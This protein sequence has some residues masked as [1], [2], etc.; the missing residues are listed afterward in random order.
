M[1]GAELKHLGH[2]PSFHIENN[3]KKC[4]VEMLVGGSTPLDFFFIL[5]YVVS[6]YSSTVECAD[7][8][9][10]CSKKMMVANS[11]WVRVIIV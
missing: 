6:K 1:N 7:I 4:W 5:L 3:R 8:I 11:M 10:V 2:H 9:V